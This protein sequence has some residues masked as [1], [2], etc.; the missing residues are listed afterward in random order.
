MDV[1]DYTPSLSNRDRSPGCLLYCVTQGFLLLLYFFT[2]LICKKNQTR[3]TELNIAILCKSF[4]PFDCI[5]DDAD[6]SARAAPS[7][8]KEF[9]P[10]LLGVLGDDQ[11]VYNIRV[12]REG[13]SY[14]S[15]VL[16]SFRTYLFQGTNNKES[17]RFPQKRWC[18][19]CQRRATGRNFTWPIFS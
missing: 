4:T 15:T 11:N 18:V 19:D 7:P 2:M 16:V 8:A 12:P 1:L 5:A 13:G 10:A 17:C 14:L 3:A 6:N 9:R